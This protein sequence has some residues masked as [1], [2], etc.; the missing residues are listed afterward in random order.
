M[1]NLLPQTIQLQYKFDLKG[2]SMQRHASA[3]ELAKRNPT[4]KDLDFI[5]EFKDGIILKN[6]TYDSIIR[7]IGRDCEVC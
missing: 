6:E 7:M 2:S 3:R 5:R 1:N 4:L